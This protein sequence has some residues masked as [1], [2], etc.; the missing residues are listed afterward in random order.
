MKLLHRFQKAAALPFVLL[1]VALNMI[2]LVALMI[3][4]TTELQ[5]SRNSGQTEIARALAQSGIDLAAGLVAA[6]STNNGFVTYQ[7]VTNV[8]GSWRLETKIANASTNAGSPFIPSAADSAV[9]HSGFA[10]GTSGVDLNFAVA[11]DS[12]AG[13]I[14]PR[15]N[16]SGWTNVSGD[17]FRMNWIYIYRGPASDPT[18]LV[19]RIAYWVDDES[20]KLNVN[21]SGNTNAYSGGG[22]T[23]FSI[24]RTNLPNTNIGNFEGRKWPVF[25]DLGGVAG[26]SRAEAIS[27]LTFRGD[28]TVGKTTNF[29]SVLA[30]RVAANTIVPTLAQQASLGFTA[31]VYSKEAERTYATGQK[32]YDLLNIYPSAPQATTIP[33][34]KSAITSNYPQ[35]DDKYDLIGFASGLYTSVQSPTNLTDLGTNSF[36]TRGLPLVNEVTIKASI[37]R[38]NGTNIVGVTYGVELITLSALKALNTAVSSTWAYYLNQPTN[39]RAEIELPAGTSFGTAVPTNAATLSGT[40]NNWFAYSGFAG[41]S[42]AA[43]S[44]ALAVLSVTNSVTNVPAP[45]WTFPSNVVVS[46][47]YKNTRY[48]SLSFAPNAPA[49]I[50]F[51]PAANQ[52]N[53]VYHMVAQPQSTNGYRGDPRFSKFSA[54]AVSA[55]ATANETNGLASLGALNPNW[56]VADYPS[57]ANSPDLTPPDIFF[58]TGDRGLPQYTVDK[59]DGFGL[60]LSGVGWIGEVPITTKSGDK[61][62]WSTPRM[63]GSGR[64]SVNGTNYPPDW[65]LF[66]CFH[67]A[68]FNQEPESPGSTNKVFN[69][70]GKISR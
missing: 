58:S 31:T 57:D 16:P 25:M 22:W 49:A 39:F 46:V 44:N 53:I 47:Y 1:L 20:S 50:N 55:P 23:D 64:P 17:M 10:A 36:N 51:S 19:G 38:T 21:Y 66:D 28:P 18:N 60:S 5:A 34:I 52:T 37:G 69:S 62:A 30:M 13:F 7:R 56:K 2:V 61:L 48:Q 12:S 11:G 63:W 4:A 29:P 35:F 15:T 32:R 14:A 67:L 6:N 42:N 65:L 27:I 26:I 3:Y 40:T 45:Q 24:R 70:Y 54:S 9:L 43:F 41:P 68:A 59:L 8:G 33:A